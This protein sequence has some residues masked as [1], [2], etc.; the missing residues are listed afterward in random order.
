MAKSITV[1]FTESQAVALC[2]VLVDDS[3]N[4]DGNDTTYL[5]VELDKGQCKKL[6]ECFN[7][8]LSEY[9]RV[10]KED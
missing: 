10:T 5:E 6:Q 8:I 2:D 3:L 1:T 4:Y 9:R 7:I